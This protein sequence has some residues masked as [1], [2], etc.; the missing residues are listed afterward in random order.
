M[1]SEDE[2]VPISALAQYAF[3][4]RRV[5]LIHSENL[6]ADNQWTIE[7][8][9]LHETTDQ[10]TRKTTAGTRFVRSLRLASADDGLYGVADVVEFKRTD[11]QEYE[12]NRTEF[13]SPGIELPNCNGLWFPVPVEFKR[14]KI[15]T[16]ESYEIQLCAQGLCLEEKFTLSIP[17]GYLYFGESGH[18]KKIELTVSL[19]QKTR[20]LAR[21]VR[22]TLFSGI[23]P[24]PEWMYKK[25]R[26]CSL[27]DLCL[28]KTVK[29]GSAEQYIRRNLSCEEE[30]K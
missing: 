22:A 17:Y 2:W 25:C 20:S 5:A 9:I 24:R 27:V 11:G 4:P 6:W 8:K 21:E 7:G 30:G 18:R 23:T 28:P 29:A 16:D 19:R 3:C 14:G 12:A 10:E 15:R 13:D 26:E 1:F